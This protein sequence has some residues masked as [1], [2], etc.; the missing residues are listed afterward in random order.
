MLYLAS[1]SP[2]RRELLARLGLG[3]S[4]L[5][6][7]VPEQRHADESAQAYVSRVAREKAL[8]G[9]ARLAAEQDALVLGCDT[10]VVLDEAV[11]GKPRD[12]ADA[13]AMLRRLSGVGHTVISAVSL[14]SASRQEAAVSVS[15]VRFAQLP[16]AV[17]DAYVDSGEPFGKAGGYAIQGLAEAF[18]ERLEGSHSGV[19]GLPLHQSARLLA[20]FGL[21]PLATGLPTRAAEAP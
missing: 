12:K 7:D 11:F 9:L 13:V 16:G 5:E 18:V 17:I 8:A 2:R 21:G 1:R 6:L 4:V 20:K 10:E 15:S 3:F 14:V 19:M